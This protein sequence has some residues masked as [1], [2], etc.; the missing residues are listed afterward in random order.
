M[1]GHV[2]MDKD[3]ED[4]PR[5]LYLTEKLLDHWVSLGVPGVLRDS[6]REGAR[7][8]AV[9][10]L[11]RLWRYADTHL[12]RGDLLNL[13]LPALAAVTGWPVTTLKHFP[14]SWLVEHPDGNVQLPDYSDKNALQVKD[15]R[16]EKTRLRVAAWRRRQREDGSEGNALPKRIGNTNER[17]SDVTTGTGSGPE[18]EPNQ[19]NPPTPLRQG[20]N[21]AHAPANR[22]PRRIRDASLEAWRAAPAA[23]DQIRGIDGRTW[24]DVRSMLAD[25]LV[26]RAIV[27]IGEGSFDQGCR[28]IAERDRYTAS[29][30]QGEFR[31]AY[32]QMAEQEGEG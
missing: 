23:I 22:K 2:R 21:G 15:N 32:E 29:R 10:G 20:G 14:Q 27:R 3:L 31:E 30:V 18:P 4:D 11:Y 19:K 12:K 24:D 5:T 8:A 17:H 25:P 9:G 7:N 1:G 26:E 6:L 13:P 28:R 16:R